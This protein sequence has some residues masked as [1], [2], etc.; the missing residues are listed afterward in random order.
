MINTHILKYAV[1]LYL[2][3]S[4]LFCNLALWILGLHSPFRS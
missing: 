1:Y 3:I 4:L 2:G